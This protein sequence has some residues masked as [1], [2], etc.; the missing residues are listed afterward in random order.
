IPRSQRTIRSFP[1][2]ATYSAAISSSSTEADGPRFSRIGLSALPTS[3][4][5]MKFC[6]LRAP[7]W[8]TS[9]A[10]STASTWRG[11]ISSVTTG[12]PV[13]SRASRRIVSASSPS[14]W[15]VYGDVRGLKAPPRSIVAPASFTARAV[16]SVCSRYSTV[17]GPAIS[18]KNSSPTFR[19]STSITVGSGE[20]SRETS[21]YGFRIGSTCSTPGYPSS[22]S[23]A[24]SS[25]SPIAPI[26]VD[27]RPRVT[28]ASAPA[29]CRRASTCSVWSGVAPEAITIKSSGDPFVAM[30]EQLK[31]VAILR[32][33]RIFSGIRASGAK[34]LGNYSGGFRQYAATQEQG[35]AFFCIVDLHSITTPFEP[36]ELHEATLDLAAMLFAT[37]LDPDRSTV[38]AQSHVTAHPEAA[39]LL[40]SVTSFGELRR[41]T[42]FKDRAAEQD[43]VSAGLFTYPVLMAGDILLYQ[44]DVVPV[45]DDQRQHVELTRDVAERFNQRFGQTFVVPDVAIPEDG[46]RIKNLQ[47]P[48]RLMSTTRGAP[49]GVVR[50]IDPPDTVRK[51]FKTAVT[52]SGTD[53]RHDPTEK[54]GISNLIEIMTVATGD[55]IGEI[56]SRYD[57]QGYGQFKQDVAEAVV[58]LLTPIQQRY[59]QLRA[60]EGQLRALLARG[61][62]KA[63]ETSAPTLERMY[64]RMG[65]VRP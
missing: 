64:E 34:T 47:E 53:V 22:G 5:S 6:M 32:P 3:A 2:R 49:Q 52:D 1:S 25:R 40:S 42:Q 8:I 33:M 46:A 41:M 54:A 7:I 58:A 13:S 14:P 50:L 29:S 24:S 23:V 63:A 19:P 38:F 36:Q 18:P 20:T 57:G 15:N 31:V 55:S 60:D 59:E 51:K 43:F 27:S 37:G 39:W 44:T 62:E 11:S 35:E 48:E 4:S 21:L 17:H 56:E 10:S 28:R 9:A 16:A 26:T 45:G 61:A 65:F 30:G 12:S